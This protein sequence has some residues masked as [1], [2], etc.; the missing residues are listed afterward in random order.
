MATETIRGGYELI[1][2][3]ELLALV[4][5]GDNFVLVDAMPAAASYQKGH[6]PGAVNLEFPLEA[7]ESPSDFAWSD[8]KKA[9]Y[10]KLLGKDKDQLVV[11]YCGFVRCAR[12]HN[13]AVLAR[14]LGYTRVK[15][16]PGGIYAWRGAGLP[17]TRD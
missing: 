14:E 17:L 6:I 10:E 5:T 9:G 2:T 15:R 12:S 8:S 7:V 3:A 11:V 4:E 13:A 1:S 16:Y